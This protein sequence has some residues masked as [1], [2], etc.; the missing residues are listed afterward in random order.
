M[1]LLAI[2]TVMLIIGACVLM[3]V[4]PQSSMALLATHTLML[5]MPTPTSTPVILSSAQICYVTV[6]MLTVRAGPGTQYSWIGVLYKHE[7]VRIYDKP[8]I[9]PSGAIWVQVGENA[10]VNSFYLACD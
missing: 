6:D 7:A 2:T 1:R 5:Y 8:V 3:P 9:L 10:W 4:A